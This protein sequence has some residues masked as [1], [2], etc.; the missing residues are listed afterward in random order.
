MQAAIKTIKNICYHF[1]VVEKIQEDGMYLWASPVLLGFSTQRE[2][3]FS[4][5][6][7]LIIVFLVIIFHRRLMLIPFSRFD[8]ADISALDL[9]VLDFCISCLPLG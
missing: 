2:D 8:D 5:S 6:P 4:I 1:G 7:F 3:F 9:F